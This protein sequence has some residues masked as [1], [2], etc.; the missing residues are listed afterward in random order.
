MGNE[1]PCKDCPDRHRACW[2][3]CAK[4]AH[5]KAEF[6]K[7]K[8]AEKEYKLRKRQDFLRSEECRA[9]RKQWRD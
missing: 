1:S 4:Y 2:D 7:A 6:D 3:Q 9:P 5:W 8:A